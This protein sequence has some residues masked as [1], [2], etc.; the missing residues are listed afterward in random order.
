MVRPPK[1]LPALT[2][3]TPATRATRRLTPASKLRAI[4]LRLRC[5]LWSPARKGP[6]LDFNQGPWAWHGLMKKEE[7]IMGRNAA[8][9]Y[10]ARCPEIATWWPL[11]TSSSRHRDKDGPSTDPR[12]STSPARIL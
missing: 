5:L 6:I 9:R 8:L 12:C 2:H 1:L 11:A 4:S 10:D 7:K 3:C